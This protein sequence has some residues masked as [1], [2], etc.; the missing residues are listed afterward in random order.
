LVPPERTAVGLRPDEKLRRIR[1]LAAADGRPVVMVGDGINDAPALAAAIGVTFA[2]A[3]DLARH[4]AAVVILGHDLRQVP[5]LLAHARLVRRTMRQN[6]AW[7]VGY[8]AVALGAAA[9]G[10]L[11]PLGAAAAML[12]SSLTVT[13]NLHRLQVRGDEGTSAATRQAVEQ[14]VHGFVVERLV[15]DV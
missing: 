5:W 4:G 13:L 10:M 15:E 3:P 2:D 6:L 1:A 7:A 14:G 9:S 11:A 12:A 8:N